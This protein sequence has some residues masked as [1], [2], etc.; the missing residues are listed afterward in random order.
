MV[1]AAVSA[2]LTIFALAIKKLSVAPR[3]AILSDAMEMS[4]FAIKNTILW[5]I[6]G[7]VPYAKLISCATEKCKVA[8][9]LLMVPYV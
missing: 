2:G 5:I 1:K 8:A 9:I 6:S 3:K 4:R 7:I